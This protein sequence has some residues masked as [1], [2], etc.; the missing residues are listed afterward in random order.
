MR[1]PK[2]NWMIEEDGSW[3]DV[4]RSLDWD[5]ASIW[6]HIPDNPDLIH[7]RDILNNDQTLRELMLLVHEKRLKLINALYRELADKPQR[8]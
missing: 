6:G 4:A 3:N 7:V 1:T 8:K 2:I 5:M